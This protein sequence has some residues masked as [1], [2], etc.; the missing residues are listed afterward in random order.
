MID[1]TP[2]IV[3]I[4]RHLRAG[5]TGSRADIVKAVAEG[6][7]YVDR[8]LGTL[9][10]HGI[11]TRQRGRYA[12]SATPEADGFSERLFA[13][14]HR[15]VRAPQKESLVRG[16]LSQPNLRYLFRLR[17][18]LEILEKEGFATEEVTSFLADE[19]RSGY[20]STVRVVFVS[21][22]PLPPP[23]Y[24]PAHYMPYF[25][26]V[27][28]DEFKGLQERYGSSGREL[29]AEDYLMGT[30]PPGMAKEAT[31]YLDREKPEITE[32]LRRQALSE[33]Y[34]FRHWG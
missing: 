8:A 3:K 26:G 28:A 16:L 4:L 12:C 1:D 27:E 6:Q 17:A 33:W 9:L 2:T 23:L 34:G 15:L 32:A 13:L 31:D 20:I 11:I 18:L 30:Y 19:S 29:K 10:S 24:I 25:Q 22:T 7:E 21:Q 5:E 14:Y